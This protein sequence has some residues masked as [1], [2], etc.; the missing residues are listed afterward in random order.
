[1]RQCFGAEIDSCSVFLDESSLEGAALAVAAPTRLLDALQAPPVATKVRVRSACPAMSWS[2]N[3]RRDGHL[4]NGWFCL[5]GERD[6]VLTRI[7]RGKPVSLNGA[8]EVPQTTQEL[9]AAVRRE[10]L[11]LGL[12][13]P[14]G[15]IVAVDACRRA[16][17]TVSLDGFRLLLNPVLPNIALEA[18]PAELRAAA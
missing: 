12:E 17:E 18:D 8:M 10:A 3:L 9:C 16:A 6:L 5:V 1:M 15:T 4:E 11:R 7:L 14:E 13:S 2:W